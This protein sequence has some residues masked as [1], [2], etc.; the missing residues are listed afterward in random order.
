MPHLDHPQTR[1]SGAVT[2]K[3]LPRG[4]VESDSRSHPIDGTMSW[5]FQTSASIGFEDPISVSSLAWD[6]LRRADWCED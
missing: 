4:F 1:A 2:R 6:L 5:A 3:P